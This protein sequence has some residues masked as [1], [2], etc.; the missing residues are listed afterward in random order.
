MLASFF[1]LLLFLTYDYIFS[2]KEEEEVLPA[3]NIA[4]I[5]EYEY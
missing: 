1:F 4:W 2:E 3:L 5:H